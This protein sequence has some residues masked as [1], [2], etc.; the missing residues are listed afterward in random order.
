MR[1]S[2]V[3]TGHVGL[4]TAATLARI[5][6]H[7]T[8]FDDDRVKVETLHAGRAPFFEPGLQ[9]LIDETVASGCL[10]FTSDPPEA[11]RDAEVA[12]ICVG[13]P[14][15]PDG[16]PML[17]AVERAA[18]SV[19]RHGG[20]DLVVVEKST[21][22]VRTAERI[23]SVLRRHGSDGVSVVSNPEFLREGQ[24][25]E[26]SLRPARILVGADDPRGHEAMRRLYA[27]LVAQGA[28]YFATDVRSAEIA[29][30]AC[31][32][33]LALKVSFAN[34]LARVCE[35]SAA[36]VTAIAEVMGS[37]PRI[38]RD[39]LSAGLGYGGYCLPKD[40]VAFRSQAARLGYEFRLLDEVVRINEE[41]LVSAFEKVKEA[42]WN[43]E[44]KRIALL[45]L[46]FKPGTDDVREAPALRLA[47]MLLQAGAEVVGH[48]PQANETARA[49]VPDL[50]VAGDPYAAAEGAH[51]LVVCT[52]WPEFRGLD[53][54]RIKGVMAHPIV[55]DGRNIFDLEVMAQAGFTYLP[56]GRPGVNL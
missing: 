1:I 34:A 2:I 13:T 47:R 51:C 12:F 10:R 39:F 50:E 42:L 48:D 16:E 35:L 53:L 33:F 22:P 40:V 11:L 20:P 30:H 9:E 41:A 26:D 27:P 3:G 18:E 45:G 49:E 36:D 14:G 29:K 54:V 32:A 7:V 43:L 52:E 17:L 4:V 19:A 38:G 31:N 5:G 28:R 15:R 25:V 8:G 21:V 55:V 56:T 24:A 6:H 23:Q 46:A 44:G 37:D